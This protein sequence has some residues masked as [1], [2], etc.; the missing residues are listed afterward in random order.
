MYVWIIIR[1]KIYL[2]Q[3]ISMLCYTWGKSVQE[4]SLL[5]CYTWMKSVQ[6]VINR[7]NISYSSRCKIT[8][9]H[10]FAFGLQQHFFYK[11]LRSGLS[12]HSCLYIQGFRGK[13]LLNG[14]QQF[15]HVCEEYNNFHDSNSIFMIN[16]FKVFSMMLLRQL[17][18]GVLLL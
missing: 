3:E 16:D 8:R 5:C 12:S 14:C 2:T 18:F 10:E 17:S 13:S 9:L 4:I 1:P 15:D 7:G 11:Q 6:K